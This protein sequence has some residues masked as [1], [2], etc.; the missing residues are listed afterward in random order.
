MGPPARVVVGAT[1]VGAGS[2]VVGTGATVVEVGA[3]VV[4]DADELGVGT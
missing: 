2:V 1:L 4:V 3:T